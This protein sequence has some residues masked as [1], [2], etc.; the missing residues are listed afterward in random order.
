MSSN[1]YNYQLL[2]FCFQTKAK[3]TET[4]NSLQFYSGKK[5]AEIGVIL[6]TIF[7]L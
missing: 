3:H 7:T 5:L 6:Q 2:I 1:W 4:F